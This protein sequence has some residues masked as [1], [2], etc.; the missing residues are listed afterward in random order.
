[1][2]SGVPRSCTTTEDNSTIQPNS[3][4]MGT[5][6]E[7]VKKIVDNK[8][9]EVLKE[10]KALSEKVDN[11]AQKLEPRGDSA[12]R[13]PTRRIF[14]VQPSRNGTTSNEGS[15]DAVVDRH[16]ARIGLLFLSDDKQSGP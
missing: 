7:H 13:Q 8:L 1:V 4:T 10:I 2:S 15:V 9:L 16:L 14:T 3:K 6:D 11:I 12:P 5:I